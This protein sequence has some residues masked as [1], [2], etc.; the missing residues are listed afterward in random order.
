MKWHEFVADLVDA[1][2]VNRAE[3][4]RLIFQQL[5]GDGMHTDHFGEAARQK[6]KP[7]PNEWIGLI[8]F[9]RARNQL[10]ERRC[11]NLRRVHA[12]VGQFFGQ[13]AR[14]DT[15]LRESAIR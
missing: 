11:F 12:K 4:P 15:R 6:T 13:R 10:L 8:E 1:L 3:I 2:V 7:V 5:G 9:A 14:L